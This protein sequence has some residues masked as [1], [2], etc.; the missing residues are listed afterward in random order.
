MEPS[1]RPEFATSEPLLAQANL[2]RIRSQWPEAVEACVRVLRSHPGNA[3]A[4]SLLGDIYRDQGALDDA[5]QWYRMAADLRPAGPD[6]AKLQKLEVER[7]RR[8]AQSAVLDPAAAA[9]A[10]ESGSPGTTQ[11]MGYSPKRWL[12]TLTIVSLSFLAATVL[13][14]AILKASSPGHA[15]TVAQPL[16]LSSHPMMPTA[17]TGVPLPG[18][19]PNRPSVLPAGEQPRAPVKIHQTGDG[20]EPDRPNSAR[21]APLPSFSQASGAASPQ[22]PAVHNREIPPAPV[23]A[24]QPLDS[25]FAVAPEDQPAP[26]GGQAPTRPEAGGTAGAGQTEARDPSIERDPPLSAATTKPASASDA[27]EQPSNGNELP[28]R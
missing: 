25:T 18:V 12:N 17:E 3:D 6:A 15:N 23:R 7:E 14:L 5:I 26:A 8:A 11:L 21:T 13:V 16:E 19:N 2:A 4:H 27:G 20:L 22:T 1:T 9:G 28:E 24:I 10:Y